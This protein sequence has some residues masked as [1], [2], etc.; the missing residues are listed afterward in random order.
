M[1]L[2]DELRSR[3]KVWA[4]QHDKMSLPL[5][6]ALGLL[7][8]IR[9]IVRHTI[10]EAA[11]RRYDKT[12]GI[13]TGGEIIGTQLR[14]APEERAYAKGYAGT[15][16]TVAERLI[17][18][19]A[20]R[21]RGFTF[22]DYGAGKGRVLLIAAR[23]QFDRVVGVELS[24]PLIRVAAANIAA[25][26]PRHPGLCPIELVQTDAANYELPQTPCVLFFYD[27][28][29]ADLM[30][31]IGQRVR[32]SFVANP[33]KLFIIYYF[34]A[35]AHVFEAPFMRRQDVTDLPGGPMNRYG[36]PTASIFETMP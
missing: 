29:Q 4:D 12:L 27:P 6:L 30:E 13:D 2:F 24:E 18:L 26:A 10:A 23:H 22:I 15:P 21:A 34:P 16:P 11:E 14:M 19:V 33:R 3:C 8:L 31:R 7:S 36:K 25:Y 28:F 5:W 17:G 9:K 20:D 1:A 35:F 32:E